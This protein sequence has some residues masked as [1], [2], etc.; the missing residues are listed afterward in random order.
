MEKKH[1]KDTARQR[2]KLVICLFITLFIAYTLF[3][4]LSFVQAARYDLE[5]TD[6]GV[7]VL[8]EIQDN[9]VED[10]IN[11]E[12]EY[13]KESIR[14]IYARASFSFDHKYQRTWTELIGDEFSSHLNLIVGDTCYESH[15]ITADFSTP[16]QKLLPGEKKEI[17]GY[18]SDSY[19]C[20]CSEENSWFWPQ[21]YYGYAFIQVNYPDYMSDTNDNSSNTKTYAIN[22]NLETAY[23]KTESLTF[24]LGGGFPGEESEVIVGLNYGFTNIETVY[25]YTYQV[26][27]VQEEEI[28]KIQ[29]GG[30]VRSIEN[31][32]MMW[33]KLEARVYFEADDYNE[34]WPPDLIIEGV[35]DFKGAYKFEIPLLAEDKD[36]PLG[37]MLVGT[38]TSIHPFK[39]NKP[40]F[41]FVD[42]E[43]SY[44]KDKN[45]LSL[46][47]WIQVYP[48]DYNSKNTD[49]GIFRINRLLAFYHL[50]KKAWS[51]ASEEEPDRFIKLTD[52][53][54]YKE[55]QD[56]SYLYTKAFDAWFFGANV[57]NEEDK[58]IDEPIK[59]ETRAI[60][61]ED[62]SVSHY[63]PAEVIIRLMEEDCK[64][65]DSSRFTL[66]HE[67]GH[68]FDSLSLFD[69]KSKEGKSFRCA[70][71]YG[72]GD[73]NHGGY[74]NS[75]TSD[76]FLEAF[77]T[78]YAALVQLYSGYPNPNILSFIQLENPSA[79]YPWSE[80][81]AFE[82]LAIASFL[83]YAHEFVGNTERYW[84]IL[85]EDRTNFKGYYDAFIDEA[86]YAKKSF[87][88]Y[89]YEA[90]LY[91]MPFG[92][93]KHDPGEPFV[94]KKDA[95]GD[96]NGVYDQG[97]EFYDLMFSLNPDTGYIDLD[98]ALGEFKREDLKIG[99]IAPAGVE[100]ETFKKPK[101]ENLLI[102]GDVP[103]YLLVDI[104]SQNYNNRNL[105][106][107]DE[108]EVFLGLPP[109]LM[110]GT[111][112]VSI[113]GGKTIYEGDLK[114]LQEKKFKNMGLTS[115]IDRIEVENTDVNYDQQIIIPC[116]GD[117][118]AS[119][120][121]E[122]P[123]VAEEEL[124]EA[125]KSYNPLTYPELGSSKV[126]REEKEDKGP[127]MP[128]G[129]DKRKNS[130]G[131]IILLVVIILS[132]IGSI[133][134]LTFLILR[135][136]KGVIKNDVLLCPYCHRPVREGAGFC[137][138]CGN[139]LG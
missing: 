55:L 15:V 22:E 134:G 98:K 61:S 34:E 139:K 24:S 45:L 112:R 32:P 79:Y 69:S 127:L 67:F 60:P 19:E 129:L 2:K 53:E 76:S 103:D 125:Q 123:Y 18:F 99:S 78:N 12:E 83:Y 70:N 7:W 82:E 104:I 49:D 77:A 51:F 111:V 81:G 59:I 54:M 8:T 68:A 85:K 87:E 66:L 114:A 106:A 93:G 62:L 33:M 57:L 50:E 27:E 11:D 128:G 117:I 90:G 73:T 95:N 47:T 64:R 30:L 108:N 72:E 109:N 31:K 20:D 14:S 97:E 135:K 63:S 36:K 102:V 121:M 124:L 94:D 115:P 17:I 39:D 138:S 116:Y 28:E 29:I 58:L 130:T 92:N 1:P 13:E 52:S 119:G 16:P 126:D 9:D 74:F 100:R 110:E 122:I 42:M 25:I 80:N 48:S 105:R 101:D 23:S 5:F 88:D 46:A 6:K 10:Y 26:E 96:S 89:A 86:D 38:L 44:S 41:Y 118:E 84:Q 131:I 4:P 75:T 132:T 113:P 136:E 71:G 133:I 43:D 40:L 21:A 56:Y 120:L 35:T 37:I 91:S 107:L 137:G 65:D 3:N